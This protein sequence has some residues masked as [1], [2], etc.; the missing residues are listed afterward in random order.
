MKSAID[1]PL[2]LPWLS[3]RTRKDYSKNLKIS[4]YTSLKKIYVVAEFTWPVRTTGMVANWVLR[5]AE[6]VI[7]ESL[8]AETD[9]ALGV[10]AAN[11]VRPGIDCPDR[12]GTEGSS[13]R[14]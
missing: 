12:V 7:V 9:S 6:N 8:C 10:G 13:T 3:S 14:P 2:C 4:A 11:P 5:R 1:Y